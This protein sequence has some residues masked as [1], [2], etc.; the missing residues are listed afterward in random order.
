MICWRI[1]GSAGGT[2][3]N[4]VSTE[5]ERITMVIIT[6]PTTKTT[7]KKNKQIK[8]LQPI[9]CIYENIDCKSSN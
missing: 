6:M 2:R 9:Q 4:S 3:L 7:E 8:Q 1:K 5:K